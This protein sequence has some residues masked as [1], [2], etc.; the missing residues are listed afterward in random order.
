DHHMCEPSIPEGCSCCSPTTATT[1]CDI[2]HPDM[3]NI[4]DTVFTQP[5]KLQNHSR[6]S[7]FEMEPREYELDDA[8]EDWRNQKTKNVYGE[9]HLIDLGPG[10]VM[11]DSVL[12][13]I[14]ACAH[15]LKIRI[16]DDLHHETQWSGTDK[17]GDEVI[18]VIHC[19]I[20]VLLS[21]SALT[22]TPLQCRLL[23]CR[24]MVYDTIHLSGINNTQSTTTV[25][26]KK[27]KCGACG[28]EGH[29]SKPYRFGYILSY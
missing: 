11:P 20:P 6:L 7:K 12:E 10:L 22:T 29:N 5:P 25:I 14:V 18:V 19:I 28:L 16:V 9:C 13:C 1:C 24:D 17:F 4:F 21:T 8:L 3:F 23:T 2:H 15:H 27:N 26:T